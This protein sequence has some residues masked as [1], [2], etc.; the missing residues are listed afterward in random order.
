MAGG[1]FPHL[2]PAFRKLVDQV[3]PYAPVADA[4]DLALATLRYRENDDIAARVLLS[5]LFCDDL[6]EAL[7]GLL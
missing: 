5:I 7:D 3:D 4:I 6:A 1:S 2:E